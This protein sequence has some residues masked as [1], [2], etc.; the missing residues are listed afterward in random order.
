MA[1][2]LESV[3]VNVPLT[4]AYNQWTQFEEFPRF[5]DGVESVRQLDETTVHFTTDIAGIRREFDTKIT[6]QIPD[7]T[8]SWESTDGPRNAGTISFRPL[9]PT[10]TRITVTMNWEPQTTLEHLGASVHFDD[11]QVKK[12]LQHFKEFIEARE[13]ETGAWRGSITEGEVEGPPGA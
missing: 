3:D 10:E 12:D 6:A 5:M 2:V 13:V 8:I 9:S 11:R 7:D 1:T 4:Q